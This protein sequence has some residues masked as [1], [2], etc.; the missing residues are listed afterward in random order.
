MKNFL[1]SLAAGT[2]FSVG[3]F[4][5][6]LL[7]GCA[8]SGSIH[9]F[10]SQKGLLA[11]VGNPDFLVPDPVSLSL[12]LGDVF[13]SRREGG[14][15]LYGHRLEEKLHKL[16]GRQVLEVCQT[17]PCYADAARKLHLS[18]ILSAT[19]RKDDEPSKSRGILT[20]TRW[21]VDPL[22]PE[23]TVPLVF[24]LANGRPS[25]ERLVDRAVS[26]MMIRVEARS[27]SKRKRSSSG[28]AANLRRLVAEGKIDQA[29]RRAEALFRSHS[30]H[31]LSREFYS[32]LYR[33]EMSAG[34]PEMAHIVGEAAIRNHHAS[35]GLI[36][37]M[38]SDA[39]R[40]GHLN[41]E[42]NIL[43][44]GLTLYPDNRLFWQQLVVEYI[45]RKDFAQAFR[46]IR[47]YVKRNPQ[48]QGHP[49]FRGEIY[50]CLVGLGRGDEADL[51]F[52]R[53]ILKTRMG[54]ATP[55]PYLAHA[56]ISRDLQKGEWRAAEEKARGLIAMGVHSTSLYTDWMT[57]L[58]AS[59]N[60]IGEARVA[61]EAISKGFASRWIRDQLAYLEQKGY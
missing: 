13:N 28:K 23:M 31:S 3:I 10:R 26:S 30:N 21:S 6:F 8:H 7:A 58:G 47:M 16:M 1:R 27:G 60:P 37:Q 17:L 19:I 46:V 29:L 24:S 54:L 5:I 48:T 53:Y 33:L 42:R 15:V 40:T 4:S 20:L 11:P 12:Y 49:R 52:R 18:F 14:T 32:T 59:N 38:A 45:H 22:F 44:Q 43:Y 41:R 50:A 39:L 25:Y 9:P 51:W 61:R 35:T 2:L 34:K 57:A 56:M 36:L 55:R